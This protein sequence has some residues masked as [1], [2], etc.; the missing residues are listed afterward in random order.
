[1]PF[2]EVPF[3]DDTSKWTLFGLADQRGIRS[4]RTRASQVLA[5]ERGQAA[6]PVG[7]SHDVASGP[8][9]VRP[10]FFP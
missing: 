9:G 7:D 10:A 1:M 3:F 8:A 4:Q 6:A 5:A 2:W